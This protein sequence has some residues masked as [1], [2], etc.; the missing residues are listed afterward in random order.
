MWICGR[1]AIQLSVREIIIS[2]P[3]LKTD[4]SRVGEQS[5]IAVQHSVDENQ[6]IA[7]GRNGICSPENR[8]KLCAAFAPLIIE[9]K[10][11]YLKI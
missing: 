7:S 8:T 5:R 3:G 11:S 4:G 9:W 2:A 10:D 6:D 1:M